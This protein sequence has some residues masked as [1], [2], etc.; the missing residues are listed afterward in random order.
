MSSSLAKRRKALT[1][2]AERIHG[3]VK[4]GWSHGILYFLDTKAPVPNIPRVPEQQ[5]PSTTRPSSRP[6]Y[7]W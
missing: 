3:K 6:H 5:A 7:G 1:K 2:R 4:M